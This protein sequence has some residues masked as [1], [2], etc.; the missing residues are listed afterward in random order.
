LRR[1][2]E[3]AGLRQ[4]GRGQAAQ[5]AVLLTCTVTSAAARQSRQAARRLARANP[6][7]RLVITGCD[8]QADHQTYMTRAFWCWAGPIWLTRAVLF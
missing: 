6:E 3:A 2:L 1:A 8:V 4:A 7:A 5:V